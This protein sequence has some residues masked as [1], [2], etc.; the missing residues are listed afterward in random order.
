MAGLLSVARRFADHLVEEFLGTGGGLDGHPIV[1]TALVELYRETGHGPYLRLAS[2]FIEQR[3]HGLIGDSGFGHRYLQDCHPVRESVTEEGHVVRALYLEAGIADVAAETG[4]AELLAR[5]AARW[6]DMVGT[7]TYLTGGNGSRHSGESF[8]DRYELPPDRA[9]N[10]TCAAIASFQWSWRLL[11]ATGESKY[12]DHMER[13]LFNTFAAATSTDGQT[14]LLRQ[15]AAAARGSLR[16]GRSRAPPR[17]VFL[18]VL[19]TQHHAPRRVASVLHRDGGRRRAARA[20]V[21]GGDDRRPARRRRPR[22]GGGKRL[23]LV[24]RGHHA[25]AQRPAGP[26]RARRPRSRLVHGRPAAS[27]RPTSRG[28][29]RR[30]RLPGPAAELA[31]RR[32]PGVGPGCQTAPDVP[33]QANRRHRRD[34]RHR[35]RPPRLL[36]RAGR[37]ACRAQR[38]GS[39][40]RGRPCSSARTRYPASGAPFSSRPARSHSCRACPDGLPFTSIPNENAV[41]DHVT[42]TAV[43][44]LHW[45]NRDGR[46]MR[47]WMP[48]SINLRGTHMQWRNGRT[49]VLV[50]GGSAP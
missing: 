17:V 50:V 41:A 19:P 30:P 14:V 42:A 15:P 34:G 47:V 33:Q 24:G 26:L 29:S 31:A 45:D 46:A 23:S 2:Q 22:S 21:P 40:H 25:R 49:K 13:I 35:A 18:R 3:G 16:R 32:C 27:Q 9:Y 48:G 1:E 10:E 44:Y 5:S 6:D 37:P 38:R 36:L 43:P 39:R 11:L 7:K 8:G 4:D 20:P 28:R 12:A